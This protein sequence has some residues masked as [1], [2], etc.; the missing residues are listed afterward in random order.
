MAFTAPLAI[1]GVKAFKTFAKFES[2]MANVKAISGATAGEFKALS[3]NAKMLGESTRFSATEVSSLQIEY[4]KLGFSAK[5][6]TKVTEATLALAQATGSD[7]AR[8]A[9]VAGAT[10]RGFGLDADETARVTDVM[11]LS[12]SSSAMDMESFAEAMKHV[13]PLA[14]TAGVSLEETT[15]MMSSL[16]DAGIK[17]SIAG[18]A[19]KRI[20]LEME[21]GSGTLAEKLEK[22][23]HVEM[24]LAGASDE[25]GDRAAAALIVLKDSIVRTNQLAEA[26]GNAEGA[27]KSMADIMDATSEGSLKRMSSAIEGLS[28]E[29]GKVLAPYVISLSEKITNLS[30]Y[31]NKL[32]DETK[33]T[34]LAF[35]GITAILGPLLIALS[36]MLPALALIGSA[37]KGLTVLQ[38]SWNAAMLANPIGAIAAVL[39]IF[40][41]GMVSLASKIERANNYQK[42]LNESQR[43]FLEHIEAGNREL[44]ERHRLLTSTATDQ[45]I[46]ADLTVDNVK[47]SLGRVDGIVANFDAFNKIMLPQATLDRIKELEEHFK[48]V[49]TFGISPLEMAIQKVKAELSGFKPGKDDDLEEWVEMA[50]PLEKMAMVAPLA[51]KQIDNLVEKSLKPAGQAAQKVVDMIQLRIDSANAQLSSLASGVSSAIQSSMQQMISGSATFGEIMGKILMD[52]VTKLVALADTFALIALLFPGSSIA[53]GGIGDFISSAMGVG[54]LGSIPKLAEGGLA[55]GPV[56]ATVGDNR[57]AKMDPEVIAPL[58]KLRGLMGENSGNIV[59][60][61]R[62]SGRDI[63]LSNQRGGWSRRRLTGK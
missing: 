7:L 59:V 26:Y 42:D 62:I 47:R 58:S 38:W 55:F 39:A 40:I 53:S 11:A 52:L 20:L 15:A 43:K 28:I 41:G 33:F 37:I 5:E 29:T 57:N 56:L 30:K 6:I 12:F 25:V 21:G 63:A 8:S 27:A 18:T 50:A 61:G 2:S 16:A 46:L 1:I 34:V 45:Q 17:G 51:A 4:S 9:E 13:A 48:N 49:E 22:L 24:N 14:K 23:S 35:A 32:S 36:M 44:Q 60:T 19:L 10:L 31:L 3:D 54:E